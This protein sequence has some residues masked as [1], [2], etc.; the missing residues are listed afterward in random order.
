MPPTPPHAARGRDLVGAEL[1]QRLAD[2]ASTE[3]CTSALMIERESLTA[4]PLA[5]IICSS[6]VARR[7]LGPLPW[8]FWRWR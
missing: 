1:G 8:R 6:E 5:A 7:P 4:T 3:P 2:D